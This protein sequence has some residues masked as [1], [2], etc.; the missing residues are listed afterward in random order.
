MFKIDTMPG[1]LNNK[2]KS[3]GPNESEY[4]FFSFEAYRFLDI[5]KYL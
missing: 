1:I 2:I 3:S 5:D 4:H